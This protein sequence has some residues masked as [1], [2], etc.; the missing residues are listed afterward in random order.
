MEVKILATKEEAKKY[1]ESA[2]AGKET[3]T[4]KAEQLQALQDGK[5]LAWDKNGYHHLIG[6]EGKVDEEGLNG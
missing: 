1:L 5:W 2:S 4:L 6:V 3:H